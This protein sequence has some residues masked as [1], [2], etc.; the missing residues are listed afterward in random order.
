MRFRSVDLS[1]KFMKTTD[2]CASQEM[3]E[4]KDECSTVADGK[5]IKK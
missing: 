4:Q 5:G 3:N 1:D 2:S